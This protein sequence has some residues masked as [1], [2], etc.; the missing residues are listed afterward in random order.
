MPTARPTALSIARGTVLAGLL[1][2]AT[3]GG[4]TP[5]ADGR[6][7]YGAGSPAWLAAV[8]RLH[9]PGS[10]YLLQETRHHHEDCSATLVGRPGATRH[11]T[12]VTAWHCLEHYRDLSRDI[13]F[14]LVGPHGQQAVRSARIIAHG[15]GMHADWAILRLQQPFAAGTV[16]PLPPATAN[17]ATGHSVTMAGFSRDAELGEGGRRLTYDAHCR[18]TGRDGANLDTDCRAYKGASG[19]AVI[20]A[21]GRGEASFSGVISEGD[22]AGLSR[23]VPV[24]RF[25]GALDLHL[26]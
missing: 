15:G 18:V 21:N 17:M 8:G 4:A 25:R 7:A 24:Q 13:T 23:F 6:L 2:L 10:R 5:A 3:P 26:R 1:L 20:E 16:T 22:G 12:I 11:D 9:V 14:T 19:G